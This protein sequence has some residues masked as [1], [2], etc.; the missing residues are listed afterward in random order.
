MNSRTQP[1]NVNQPYLGTAEVAVL[2]NVAK[3][4]ICNWLYRVKVLGPTFPDPIVELRMGPIWRRRDILMFRA[5]QARW[6]T[7]RRRN[8]KVQK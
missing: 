5:E 4:V 7:I 1:I 8:Q 6:K 3:A 2:C